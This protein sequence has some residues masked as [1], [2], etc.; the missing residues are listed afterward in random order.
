MPRK[1]TGS[2]RWRNGVCYS[3]ITLGPKDRPA[4]ALPTC[5]TDEEARARRD[6]LADLADKLRA[7]GQIDLAPEFLKRAGEREG[8]ALD[9]VC[10]A[11]ERLCAGQTVRVGLTDGGQTS[12]PSPRAG[13]TATSTGSIP[14]T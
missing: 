2:F 3:R 13:R 8:K 12:R 4:F 6:I 5:R 14:I 9:D 7:S 1:A 10:K 11:V